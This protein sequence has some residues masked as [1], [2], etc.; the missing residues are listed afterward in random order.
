MQV[1]SHPPARIHGLPAPPCYSGAPAAV[2]AAE[3]KV[4]RAATGTAALANVPPGGWHAGYVTTTLG[5]VIDYFPPVPAPSTGPLPIP[6]AAD[7]GQREV[8]WL[9]CRAEAELTDH[10][11]TDRAGS[12]WPFCHSLLA[13]ALTPC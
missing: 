7:T 11:R 1:G 8:I 5:L 9:R 4:E 2:A 3:D 6:A 13:A 12:R 10:G